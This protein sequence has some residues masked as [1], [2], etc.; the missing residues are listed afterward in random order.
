MKNKIKVKPGHTVKLKNIA[1]LVT[2]PEE[3]DL[4]ELFIHE[5]K[6]EDNDR[7]VIDVLE[8]I[9]KIQ[10]D[11]PQHD[12]QLIGPAQTIIEVMIERKKVPFILFILVWILLF[13]GAAMAIMN[14]HEDV[15]MGYV[16]QRISYMITGI[17]SNSPLWFQI[18]YSIGIGLG[19]ILFFNHVFKKRFNEE[20]SPMEWNCLITNKT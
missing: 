14:F 10:V 4:D 15:S 5:V 20:P 16:Q 11:F 1:H 9:N 12:V 19:M 8:V 7:V 18:P 3:P 17:N 13:I 2:R 6:I